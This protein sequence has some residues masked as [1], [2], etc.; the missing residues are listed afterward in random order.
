MRYK[1]IW[2]IALRNLSAGKKNVVKIVFGV[3]CS[4]VLALC[5]LVIMDFYS[6]YKY[7][8]GKKYQYSCYVFNVQH[9]NYSITKTKQLI[10][11]E[12][13]NIDVADAGEKL[14]FINVQPDVDEVNIE[15][16]NVFI[17]IDNIEYEAKSF[18]TFN[19]KA[20]EDI[21]AASSEI[22][23]G[24]YDEETNVFPDSI[25]HGE[26]DM[27]GELPGNDGEVMIDDYLLKVYGINEEPEN[28]I[29][30]NISILLKEEDIEFVGGDYTITGVFNANEHIKREGAENKFWDAHYEHIW[31]NFRPEDEPELVTSW[32]SYR[33]YYRDYEELLDKF[34]YTKELI[35]N[36]S[37]GNIEELPFVLTYECAELCTLTWI[38]GNMGKL[39]SVIGGV[40]VL[41]ILFSLFYIVRFY[42]GRN[43][44]YMKMLLCIGMEQKDRNRLRASEIAIM[45]VGAVL[46][47]VYITFIFVIVF[48][49][50]SGNLLSYGY[51][52]F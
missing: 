3:G 18:F 50:I 49:Y 30:K 48:Q 7:E 10:E 8:F 36:P 37:E 33:A 20:Y 43:S 29:G 21:S 15:A 52:M 38:M 39:L 26:I 25:F 41:V 14:A 1:D 24:Y 4:L 13:E 16:K 42:F 34:D 19:R 6:D 40:V 12:F 35:S 31:V 28:L 22:S 5:Y 17:N 45:T 27:V 51:K 11:K 47:A 9:E 46:I 44:N 32:F 23:V 2:T